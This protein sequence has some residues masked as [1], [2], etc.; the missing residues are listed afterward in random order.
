MCIDRVNTLILPSLNEMG[1]G[2]TINDCG[3]LED[4]FRVNPPPPEQL[5]R[6]NSTLAKRLFYFREGLFELVSL[7]KGH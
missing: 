7:E 4:L 5:P 6:N 3:G 1:K 2:L